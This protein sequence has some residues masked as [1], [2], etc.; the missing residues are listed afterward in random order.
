MMSL[1]ISKQRKRFYVKDVRNTQCRNKCAKFQGV[2]GCFGIKLYHIV[3]V[4]K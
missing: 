2:G 3:V 4:G 1:I